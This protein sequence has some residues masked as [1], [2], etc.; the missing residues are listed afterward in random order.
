MAPQN[1]CLAV[2]LYSFLAMVFTSDTDLIQEKR[3]N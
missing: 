2:L 1:S 3:E